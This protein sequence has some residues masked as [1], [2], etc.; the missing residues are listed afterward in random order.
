MAKYE[1]LP[2]QLIY[3]GTAAATDFY[4][5]PSIGLEELFLT[6]SPEY[7]GRVRNGL[8]S[9][10]EIRA[11]GFPLTSALLERE[12]RITQGTL[13][14]ARQ[15]RLEGVALNIAGG[16]H[17][18]FRDHG[19]GFC[20]FN[21]IAVAVQVLLKSG[22]IER[23]IVIDLDV[24]QGNGTASLF[25]DEPRVFTM[26]YHGER[27]YPLRKESSDLDVGWPDG[28]GDDAYL[29][30]LRT[31]LPSLLDQFQPDQAFYL[32][33]VDVLAEDKLGRL[34]LTMAGCRERD[35]IVLQTCADRNLPVAVSMGGGYPERLVTL[36]EAHANTYRIARS[37][38]G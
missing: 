31:E 10:K 24:H 2:Q 12:L 20:V 11:L 29:A 21:D 32:S 5:P 6:H 13:W 15:S 35:R 38:F 26:S 8:L 27:N 37:I 16:T 22:E 28:T 19:E 17:H 23:A 36:I 33:G 18:S 9:P 34:S 1:L 7:Y 30:R 4:A 3:E 14:C 25:V